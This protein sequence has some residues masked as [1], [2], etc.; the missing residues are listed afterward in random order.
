MSIGL[1]FGVS[2]RPAKVH[3]ALASGQAPAPEAPDTVPAFTEDELL[4]V[5]GV[6]TKSDSDEMAA[7]ARIAPAL[8]TTRIRHLAVKAG[9]LNSSHLVGMAH[10]W[11]LLHSATTPKPDTSAS[12]SPPCCRTIAPPEVRSDDARPAPAAAARPRPDPDPA[13]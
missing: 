10:A 8:V 12:P 13:R 3:A 1:K 6:A 11:Q 5:R 4:L 7:A 9:A 2:S